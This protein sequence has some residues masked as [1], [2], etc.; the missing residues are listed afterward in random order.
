MVTKFILYNDTHNELYSLS[1]N[2]LTGKYYIEVR[3][4]MT[5][6]EFISFKEHILIDNQYSLESEEKQIYL[7]DILFEEN[8]V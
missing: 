4:S 5:Y 2:N 1:M 6:E 8:C 7:L 3:P